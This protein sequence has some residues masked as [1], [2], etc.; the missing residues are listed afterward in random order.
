LRGAQKEVNFT[1][2]YPSY[3][4]E[5]DLFNIFVYKAGAYQL[6]GHPSPQPSGP[7]PPHS[8]PTDL[9]RENESVCLHY[10]NRLQQEVV[11]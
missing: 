11:V 5:H 2:V 8:D 1:I 3:T 6:F 7:A 9:P 10:K 4:A